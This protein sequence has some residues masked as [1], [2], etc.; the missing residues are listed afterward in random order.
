MIR[1]PMSEHRVLLIEDDEGMRYAMQVALEIRLTHLLPHHS[2][3]VT[4]ARHTPP[5]GRAADRR[6]GAAACRAHDRKQQGE[7]RQK[8]EIH[9][10]SITAAPDSTQ[11]DKPVV[12][13]RVTAGRADASDLDTEQSALVSRKS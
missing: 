5:R 6:R 3:R 1:D 11:G 8:E 9:G 13:L 2:H 12:A 7:A 10:P 4:H